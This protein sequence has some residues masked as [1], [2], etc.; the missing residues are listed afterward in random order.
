MSGYSSEIKELSE[1]LERL[2]R[3]MP[4]EKEPATFKSVFRGFTFGFFE[5]YAQWKY[6]HPFLSGL[7][8]VFR[9]F[10]FSFFLF[11]FAWWLAGTSAGRV[12]GLDSVRNRTV[13]AY[14]SVIWASKG[15]SDVDSLPL[16]PKRFS[17][18]IEKIAGDVLIVSYYDQ[19][20]SVRRLVRPA[21]VIITDK[22]GFGE[23]ASKYLLKGITIDFY[24][25]I[26]K[27]SGYD[28]WGVVLWSKRVPVNVQL[29]ELGYGT[30][31]KNPET[32]VVNSIF[33]RYYLQR[34]RSG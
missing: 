11:A 6:E 10:V 15:M 30:P 25:P 19:G 33:S 20:K 18:T 12:T 17:G 32:Q 21:N 14:Y 2:L 23:W 13:F 24:T 31:E 3:Q 5:E 22:K 1:K 8:K 9:F 27:A 26:D 16:T 28:V 7:L 29:V 34:A 4:R